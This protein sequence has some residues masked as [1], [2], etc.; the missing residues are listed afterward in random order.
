MCSQNSKCWFDVQFYFKNSLQSS[1]PTTAVS[2]PVKPNPARKRFLTSPEGKSP[3]R[4]SVRV[5]S[6][7]VN[8][9]NKPTRS[10]KTLAFDNQ[11]D[12]VDQNLN[13][14]D[15][16]EC[17]LQVKVV[18]RTESGNV[19]VRIPREEDSKRLVRHI[20][21]K[22]WH[23]VANALMKH[24]EMYSEV[25]KA[26]SKIAA[27]ET[28]NYVKTES[29]LLATKPDEIIGFS[30]KIFVEELRVFCP[31]FY[32][33]VVHASC[34]QSND[35]KSTGTN[36]NN[37]A[38]A[39]AIICKLRNPKASALHH[40]ISTVLFHSGTK[41][42]D[43]VKLNKL[44]VCMS[45]KQMVCSQVEM[46]KQLEGKV[47]VWKAQIEE[48]TGAQLLLK[49]VQ[50]KQATRKEEDDMDIVSQIKLDEETVSKY[51]TFSQRGHTRLLKEIA[52]VQ[53]E[54]ELSTCTDEVLDAVE[55]KLDKSNMPL[56]RIVGD[57]IDNEKY[58]RVQ[59]KKHMNRSIHWT[60][61]FAVLDR[62]QVP[63]MEDT[64]SQRLVKDLQFR[65]LLP[66]VK[67]HTNLLKRWAVLVSRIVTKYMQY[68]GSLK[69]C[70]IHHIKHKHTQ[71]IAPRSVVCCLG[72]EFLNP[73]VAGDMAQ[74]MQ[75]NQKKYVPTLGD[76]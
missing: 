58:V 1:T 18:L 40:R 37:V 59:T 11:Q 17:G 2:T 57:N 34:L 29:L 3:A 14:D 35:V 26:V 22:K 74:L 9:E 8:K 21:E 67:V 36:T 30:S 38:L 61:Q 52:T 48:Q 6:P 49:E 42:D 51:K 71:E 31:M 56:Y 25:V 39:S 28:A 64:K 60:H 15:L 32:N 24:S 20:C 27:N 45:P 63:N 46:G 55:S 75:H 70:T 73:N 66:D 62:V 54:E 72:M 12:N 23:A 68:F 44:G 43:L 69:K 10:R 7:N 33:I 13:I 19:L 4:K 76:S 53:R 47:C 5:L 50:M 16:P 41:H 65:E